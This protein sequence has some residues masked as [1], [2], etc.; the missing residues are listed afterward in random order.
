MVRFLIIFILLLLGL[1]FL[2]NYQPVRVVM[3][4]PWNGWLASASFWLIQWFDAAVAFSGNIIYRLGSG[5]TGGGV[6][7]E[8]GCNGIEAII[9]LISAMLAFPGPWLAKLAGIIIGAALVQA[10]NLVRIISLFY[11]IEWDKGLFE[12]FHLYLWPTLIIIDALVVFFIWMR[13]LER[14]VAREQT[15]VGEGHPP[16]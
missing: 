2:G 6:S 3:V 10:L 9:I 13:L 11:L 14:R 1:S 12:W 8:S 15:P 5:D 7:I 16:Q 4:D